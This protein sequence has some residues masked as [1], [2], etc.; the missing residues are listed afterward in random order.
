MRSPLTSLTG[1]LRT[2]RPD[3]RLRK[4]E[5]MAQKILFLAH[6]DESGSALPRVAHECLGAVLALAGRASGSVTIG[7]VGGDIQ[8]AAKTIA[9]AGV[10][11]IGVSGAEFSHP[12]YAT[13]AAA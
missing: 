5:F 3:R 4:E 12:R 7:I 6:V 11:I 9:S 1:S 8:N 13:D 2:R 10:P